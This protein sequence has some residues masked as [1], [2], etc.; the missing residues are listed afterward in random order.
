[1][2]KH[3]L[4]L[5]QDTHELPADSIVFLSAEKRDWLAGRYVSCNWDLEEFMRKKEDIVQGD[6]LKVKL[7]V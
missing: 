2:P 4:H 5:L 6:L 7:Q 3:M 1:M